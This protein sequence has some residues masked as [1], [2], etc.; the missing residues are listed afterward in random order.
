MSPTIALARDCPSLLR[1]VSR[2]QTLTQVLCSELW[3]HAFPGVEWSRSALDATR[4]IVGRIRPSAEK[5]ASA[6]TCPA[7]NCGSDGDWVTA[8]QRKR[9]LTWLTRRVPRVDT[10][11]VVRMALEPAISGAKRGPGSTGAAEPGAIVFK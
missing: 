2:R 6:Q 3:L 7:R 9:I 4:F 5:N 1:V 11:Y 8:T 10:M